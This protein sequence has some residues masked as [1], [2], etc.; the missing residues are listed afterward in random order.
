MASPAAPVAA[1]FVLTI[2]VRPRVFLTFAR[3]F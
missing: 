3:V 1:A 2:A